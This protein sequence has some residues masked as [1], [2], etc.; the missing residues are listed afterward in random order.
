MARQAAYLLSKY[1]GS[2]ARGTMLAFAGKT[3]SRSLAKNIQRQVGKMRAQALPP[4]A[5]EKLHLLV[6]GETKDKKK[7][8]AVILAEDYGKVAET[9]LLEVHQGPLSDKDTQMNAAFALVTPNK[10]NVAKLKSFCD[11]KYRK[12]LRYSAAKMLGSNGAAGKV[13]LKELLKV[14]GEP[15]KPHLERFINEG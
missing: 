8:A 2:E 11:R 13:V 4:R 14:K 7:M 15:L 9:D 3:S 6:F 1:G 12:F 5:V 10:K